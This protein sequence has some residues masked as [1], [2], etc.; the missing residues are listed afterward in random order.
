MYGVRT[1]NKAPGCTGA[2]MCAPGD[3]GGSP[4]WPHAGS[5]APKTPQLHIMCRG[6]LKRALHVD[7]Y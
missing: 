6:G 5:S 2:V 3:A 4:S 7:F 1:A